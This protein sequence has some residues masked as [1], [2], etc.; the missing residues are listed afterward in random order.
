LKKHF[1]TFYSP[2]TFF[3]ESTTKSIDSWDVEQAKEM[4]H[5]VMER[6]GATPHS[7]RFSTR[8]R[9]KD[10]LDSKVT[11]NSPRYFLGGNI[12]TLEDIK[13]RRD[14]NDKILISNMEG[15]GWDRV[16]ENTSF[17]RYTLPFEKT[18]FI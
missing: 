11:K 18:I 17:W 9:G 5:T 14:K 2:G 15:N 16:I 10:D 1:V 6:Y 4:A 7:F 13:A 12:L 3:T 8:E